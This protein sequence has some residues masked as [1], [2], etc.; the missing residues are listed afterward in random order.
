MSDPARSSEPPR[1]PATGC[2]C[3]P[4][5][6]RD[7]GEGYC[8]RCGHRLRPAPPLRADPH[9][10]P[11][12]GAWTQVGPR[13][14]DNQDA[15]AIGRRA[16]G[17]LALV[18]C[19]GVSSSAAA[20]QAATAAATVA[21]DVLVTPG[22]QPDAER[23]A[24]AVRAAHRA[25]VQQ[26]TRREPGR[27]PP[28]TTIVAALARPGMVAVAWIGDSRAYLLEA[29]GAR[30]LTRDDSWVA[31]VVDAGM[32]EA[33]ARRA[34][35][36]HALLRCIGPLESED[37]GEEPEPGVVTAQAHAAARLLL[38]SDGLWGVG[39]VGDLVAATPPGLDAP[40]LAREL[41]RRALAAGGTD[42]VAVA[43]AD[44]PFAGDETGGAGP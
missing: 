21:C 44:L 23:A 22:G 42:D 17:A 37:T 33:E 35:Q 10:G 11:D 24:A 31:A 36:A 1:P 43:V 39:E 20:A 28:G 18:V 27:D 13:H 29:G 2:P 30:L 16:D 26:L 4:G 5:A 19:D 6:G 7:D 8:N 41:V 38:C 9:S 25:V 12:L 3:G 32:P 15:V 34:P 14:P 40:D